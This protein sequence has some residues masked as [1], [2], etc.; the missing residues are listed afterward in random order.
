[1]EEE[2]ELTLE[3][4]QEIMREIKEMPTDVCTKNILDKIGAFLQ[5]EV[6]DL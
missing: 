4:L 3:W 5:V 1:M 2:Y 6:E